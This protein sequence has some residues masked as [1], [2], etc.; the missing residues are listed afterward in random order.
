MYG[1]GGNTDGMGSKGGPGADEVWIQGMAFNPA[2]ITVTAG[3]TITWTNMDSYAHTVTSD[4]T[5]LF[6]SGS[7]SMG[8][9]YSGGGSWSHL[10]S[11]TGTYTYHCSIHPTMKGKVIVN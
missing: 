7:I 2:I 4:S 1:T 9:A 11:T 10:F 5:G 8:D 3:T 6:N